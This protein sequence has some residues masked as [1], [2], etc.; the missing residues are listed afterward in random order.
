MLFKAL[1]MLLQCTVCPHFLEST[2]IRLVGPSP[3]QGRVEIL[4]NGTW[5]TVCDN[6][7]GPIDSKIVCRMLGFETYVCFFF[8]NYVNNRIFREISM[9]HR[10]KHK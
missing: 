5:G 6:G 4:Y 7:F 1:Q 9:R 10:N 8:I 2:Q 3:Y